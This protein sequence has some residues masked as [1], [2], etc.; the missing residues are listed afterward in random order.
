MVTRPNTASRKNS[1]GPNSKIS[2]LATGNTISRVMTPKRPPS[3]EA[4]AAEPMASAALP[5]FASGKPSKVVAAFGAVPGV[6][7]RMAE[8]APPMATAPIIPPDMAKAFTVLM[9]KVR[10]IRIARAV[11]PPRPGITPK[12][13]PNITPMNRNMIVCTEAISLNALSRRSSTGQTFKLAI[14]SCNNEGKEDIVTF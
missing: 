12:I 11:V 7:S 13:K 2:C 6:L 14:M 10:G 4:V 9:P 8:M 1:G 3:G 5:C